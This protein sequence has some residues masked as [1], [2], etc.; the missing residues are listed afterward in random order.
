MIRNLESNDLDKM[1]L[2]LLEQ[3][4]VVNKETINKNNFTSFIN[5]LNNR[6]QILVIEMDKKIV[7]TGTILVEPKIIHGLSKVA[8]IEDVVVDK[9]KRGLGLGKTIMETLLKIAKDNNCYKIILDSSDKN[10]GFYQK[11]GF[12]KKEN[13]N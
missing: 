1:Y 6:H 7:A 2:E 5:Q 4:T 10:V 13:Q 11:C 8:H 9:G 12:K 3:L